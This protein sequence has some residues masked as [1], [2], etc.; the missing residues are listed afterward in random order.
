LFSLL[1]SCKIKMLIPRR[2]PLTRLWPTIGTEKQTGNCIITDPFSNWHAAAGTTLR[3]VDG[4]WYWFQRYQVA[5]QTQLGTECR[6]S[7]DKGKTW[8][9]PVRVISPTPGTPWS[10]MAT[11]G[12]FFYDAVANKWRCLFQSLSTEGGGWTCSYVERV[13]ADPM[14][15]FTT[16]TGF[17]NPAINAKEY[18][19]G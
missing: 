13:G 18:G 10:R 9:E 17:T 11:D 12:D 1:F 6:K 3:V 19:A 14:G 16:P 15:T 5:G 8:S 4:T 7:T 2:A